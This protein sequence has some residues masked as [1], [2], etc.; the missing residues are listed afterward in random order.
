[1][2]PAD[3]Q[4]P[5][6]NAQCTFDGIQNR[7]RSTAVWGGTNSRPMRAVERAGYFSCRSGEGTRLLRRLD[8]LKA[9]NTEHMRD[10]T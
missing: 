1:L 2:I 10:K 5:V 4:L 6:R 9:I 8:S 3:L 7:E